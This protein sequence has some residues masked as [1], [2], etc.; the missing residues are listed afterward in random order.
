MKNVLLGAVA[1]LIVLALGIAG[2]MY[3]IAPAPEGVYEQDWQIEKIAN[4]VDKALENSVKIGSGYLETEIL[5]GSYAMEKSANKITAAFS[6][7]TET[8]EEANVNINAKYYYNETVENLDVTSR[9]Y[10]LYLNL[11]YPYTES[12]AITRKSVK[13]IEVE[14]IKEGTRYTISYDGSHLS[15]RLEWEYCQVKNDYEIYVID[16]NGVI[17]RYESVTYFD[18]QG[19][20]PGKSGVTTKL[21]DYELL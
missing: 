18:S 7:D 16:E 15:R 11:Y 17:T 3:F 9:H 5:K 8:K 10:G 2:Y 13:S 1:G 19:G 12:H 14:K 6:V 4:D 21:S 20:V